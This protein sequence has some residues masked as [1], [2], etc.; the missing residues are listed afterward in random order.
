MTRFATACNDYEFCYLMP[1]RAYKPI[2]STPCAYVHVRGCDVLCS[3]VAVHV[4]EE[5]S[6]NK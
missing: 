2:H 6:A 1:Y 4:M 3:D 5:E